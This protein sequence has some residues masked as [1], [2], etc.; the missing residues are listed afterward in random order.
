MNLN[1]RIHVHANYWHYPAAFCLIPDFFPHSSYKHLRYCNKNRSQ[2]Q[3][4]HISDTNV[5][6]FCNMAV[7]KGFNCLFGEEERTSFVPC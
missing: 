1:Y 6:A 2:L 7:R 4:T 3:T 5:S